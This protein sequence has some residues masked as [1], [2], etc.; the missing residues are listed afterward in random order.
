MHASLTDKVFSIAEEDAI[1]SRTQRHQ[2]QLPAVMA[3]ADAPAI[4]R[5]GLPAAVP[6]LKP[7]REEAFFIGDGRLVGGHDF[8]D[9]DHSRLRSARMMGIPLQG[10][11]FRSRS[12]QR[13]CSVREAARQRHSCQDPDEQEEGN[14]HKASRS[15][16]IHIRPLT[17]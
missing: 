17:S 3:A 13:P 12:R 9:P 8:I 5:P 7:V 14:C 15:Y 16:M 4:K 11:R 1:L 2:R 6:K 10:R